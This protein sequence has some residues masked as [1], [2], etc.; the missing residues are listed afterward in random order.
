[1]SPAELRGVAVGVFHLVYI[2]NTA[3]RMSLATLDMP[4]GILIRS[5]N[6]SV[7]AL[8]IPLKVHLSWINPAVEAVD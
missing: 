6:V 5:V 3:D 7:N 4:S 1:M 8:P 2:A